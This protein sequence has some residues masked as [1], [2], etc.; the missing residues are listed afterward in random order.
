[1]E[2]LIAVLYVATINTQYSGIDKSELHVSVNT[3]FVSGSGLAAYAASY[4]TVN[5]WLNASQLINFNKSG[6]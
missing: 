3:M 1:M 6:L 2:G 4:V 5:S